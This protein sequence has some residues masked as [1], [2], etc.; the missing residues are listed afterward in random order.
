MT[1]T[2]IKQIV[3]MCVVYADDAKIARTLNCS[4]HVVE[5][6]RPMVYSKT[7][8]KSKLQID[9]ETKK[10]SQFLQRSLNEQEKIRIATQQLLI[11]QLETG[12]HW[13]SKQRFYEAISNLKPEFGLHEKYIL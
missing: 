2:T 8:S 13:L 11:R 12:H 10:Y 9:P 7:N 5:A 3:D 1:Q 4:K 6:C